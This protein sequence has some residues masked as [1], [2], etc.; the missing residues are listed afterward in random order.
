M[1]AMCLF[2]TELPIA[3]TTTEHGGMSRRTLVL[4]QTVFAA[5]YPVTSVAWVWL[6]GRCNVGASMVFESSPSV[7]FPGTDSATECHSGTEF[8]GRLA[9]YKGAM[10]ESEV[11]CVEVKAGRKRGESGVEPV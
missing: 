3:D 9:G 5:K 4:L 8:L 6:A 7:K 1:L 10:E 11:Y 2:A